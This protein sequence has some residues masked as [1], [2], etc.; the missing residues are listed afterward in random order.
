MWSEISPVLGGKK[1]P[2]SKISQTK[3]RRK[4]IKE[5]IKKIQAALYC[6]HINSLGAARASKFALKRAVSLD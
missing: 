3:E 5:Q 4:N 6:K 2:P 1:F